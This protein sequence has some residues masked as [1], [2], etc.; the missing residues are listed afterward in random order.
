MALC[1]RCLAMKPMTR[2]SSTYARSNN[3]A[4]NDVEIIRLHGMEYR[5]FLTSS[6]RTSMTSP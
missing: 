2:T 3:L 5:P 4:D 6:N 1:L